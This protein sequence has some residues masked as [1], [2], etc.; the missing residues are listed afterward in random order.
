MSRPRF[1][2]W[3]L[4]KLALLLLRYISKLTILLSLSCRH[5][6]ILDFAA[7]RGAMVFS[8]VEPAA[9][10]FCKINTNKCIHRIFN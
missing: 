9:N 2:L 10:I 3:P 1:V 5:V 6:K 8:R 7:T 4:S